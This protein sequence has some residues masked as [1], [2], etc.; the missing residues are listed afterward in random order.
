VLGRVDLWICVGLCWVFRWSV[1]CGADCRVS[2]GG[3]VCGFVWLVLV[4]LVVVVVVVW[5]GFCWCG[6]WGLVR[7]FFLWMG[8]VVGV[9]LCVCGVWW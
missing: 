9:W 4:F 5:L 6:G 2:E 1:V 8:W 3:V 7:G